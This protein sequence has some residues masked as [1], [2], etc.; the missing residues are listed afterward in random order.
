MI[1]PYINIYIYTH[2]LWCIRL[3]EAV[4]FPLLQV[5]ATPGAR[6]EVFAP[7]GGDSTWHQEI[8]WLFSGIGHEI[9]MDMTNQ[10]ILVGGFKHDFYFPFHT[11]DVIPTPLTNSY[12]SRWWLHHQAEYDMGIIH[13]IFPNIWGENLRSPMMTLLRSFYESL[14]SWGKRRQ[15]NGGSPMDGRGYCILFLGKLNVVNLVKPTQWG[16]SL[17]SQLASQFVM[18]LW[19]ASIHNGGCSLFI[20]PYTMLANIPVANN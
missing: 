11:W 14:V 3:F 6:T 10:P 15:G 1:Y 20:V 2:T 4:H 13:G 8:P 19:Y 17:T 18:E 16:C 9:W 5:L 12:F 7:G